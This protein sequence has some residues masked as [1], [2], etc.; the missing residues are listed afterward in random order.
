M[1]W[2]KFKQETSARSLLGRS[3]RAAR[4][5]DFDECRQGVDLALGLNFSLAQRLDFQ[6]EP[7]CFRFDLPKRF[8]DLIALLL[9]IFNVDWHVSPQ[10][11]LVPDPERLVSGGRRVELRCLG[12]APDN[13]AHL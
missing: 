13:L 1:T 2:I 5:R 6:I 12:R 10:L 8:L 4:V 7:P 3:R 11:T 9:E